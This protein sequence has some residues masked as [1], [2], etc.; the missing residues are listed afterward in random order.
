MGAADDSP[1]HSSRLSATGNEE[2]NRL[3]M[4]AVI[5]D[6]LRRSAR[7]MVSTNSPLVFGGTEFGLT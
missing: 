5:G 6:I 1:K 4:Y 7:R 3:E 2:Q